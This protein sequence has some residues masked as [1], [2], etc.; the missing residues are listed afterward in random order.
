MNEPHPPKLAVWIAESVV[1]DSDLREAALGDLAEDFTARI[2]D[3]SIA[4]ANS[5]YWSQVMR[6]VFPLS[7]MSLRRAGLAGWLR[8]LAT[9]LVTYIALA[10]M[11][12]ISDSWIMDISQNVWAVS[13]MSL[14]FGATAAVIAGYVAALVGGKTPMLAALLLGTLCLSLGLITFF[15]FIDGDDGSPLLYRVVL[16][17]S[18]LPACAFGAMLRTRQLRRGALTNDISKESKK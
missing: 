3:D 10:A 4:G 6:S 9:V 5:W 16:T 14:A 15:G 17:L 2:K 18:V 8:L 12:I 7:L 1:S 11:V 13:I